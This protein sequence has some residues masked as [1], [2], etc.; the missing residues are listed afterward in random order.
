MKLQ[1]LYK[2]TDSGIYYYQPPMAKGIRP[3]PVSLRTKDEAEAVAAYYEI[4]SELG[5]TYR[6]GSLRMEIARYL[7]AKREAQ[8]HTEN[9]GT[10]SGRFLNGL[11]D[12]LGNREVS[13]YDET[14]LKRV[15]E[16]WIRQGLA[17]P[18]IATYI[19]R[20]RAFFRWAVDE[21]LCK[22]NPARALRL[23]KTLPTRAEKYVTKMERDALIA[24]LPA[25]RDD[26][27]L[28]LWLGFFAGL[29]RGEIDQV[30]R[31]WIDL[32][33]GVIHVQ[34]TATFAPKNKSD[35]LIRI[36][37]RLGEFLAGYMARVP[38]E[39]RD[40]LL[41]PDK[42][43][44]KKKRARGLKANR[45]RWDARHPF[46]RFVKE[47][48]MEWVGFHTMRHTWATL[49]AL[50]G[51]PIAVLAKELGDTVQTTSDHYIGYQR[52]GGHAEAID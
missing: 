5:A 37:P 34:A 49:H 21:G 38:G 4:A 12:L 35:R 46:E 3:K 50:A 16:H 26:L 33:A 13:S 30:H 2:K 9:S 51:T 31:R 1:G 32:E 15:G 48:K 39:P 45:Y 41:R 14:D 47:Q 20:L 28:V 40:F 6:K 52:Q 8:E 18:T 42:K 43:M 44:G 10:E 29:R 19:K 22:S 27:S 17:T 24:A 23:P 36:S 7:A 11:I 25:A